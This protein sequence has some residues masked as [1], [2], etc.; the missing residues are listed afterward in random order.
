MLWEIGILLMLLGALAVVIG[1][2]HA[3]Q[4]GRR[5]GT[6]TLLITGVNWPDADG[7]QWVTITGVIGPT[8][9]EHVV[10]SRWRSA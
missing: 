10:A 4:P 9:N 6:G 1:P 5:F 7:Q 2:L 8:V 3:P